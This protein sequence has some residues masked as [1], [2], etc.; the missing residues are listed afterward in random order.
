[1]ARA[2]FQMS[3]AAEEENRWPGLNIFKFLPLLRRRSGG[4]G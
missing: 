3:P 4:Q 2:N 1:M